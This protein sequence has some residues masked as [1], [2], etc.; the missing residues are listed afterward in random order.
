MKTP[1][2]VILS[3]CEILVFFSLLSCQA[4]EEAF[5]ATIFV[6]P[7]TTVEPT[8][9]DM[10]WEFN[11]LEGEVVRFL[12]LNPGQSE[13]LTSDYQG[14]VILELDMENLAIRD[15]ISIPD[16]FLINDLCLGNEIW[17]IN[18][19]GQIIS[20]DKEKRVWINH[21]E[22][23]QLQPHSSCQVYSDDQVF[24]WGKNWI[25]IHENA[26]WNVVQLDFVDEPLNGLIR[27]TQDQE[28][29]LWLITERGDIY[30]LQ[31]DWQYR[32]SVQTQS[33]IYEIAVTKNNTVWIAAFDQVFLWKMSDAY[34]APGIFM[35]FPGNFFFIR[36]IYQI[37]D[38]TVWIVTAEGIISYG[39]GG[40]TIIRKPD[41]VRNIKGSVFSEE[42]NKLFITTEKGVYSTIVP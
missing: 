38:D 12:E 1:I 32:G 30:T 26:S 41:G 20:Y 19:R 17:A 5:P 23:D 7:K 4:N 40:I 33:P 8:Y 28:K 29:K 13:L 3:I 25:A 6:E 36:A 42:M 39:S 16:D 14:Q 10:N 22:L 37:T 11:S 21:H 35:E 24:F 18:Y 27:L 31:E 9:M 2:R 15:R 34:Q